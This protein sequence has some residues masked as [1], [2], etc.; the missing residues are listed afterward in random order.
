MYMYNVLNKNII[1]KI[2]TILTTYHQLVKE[3]L[4]NLYYEI[5]N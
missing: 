1:N 5:T 4:V 2:K 3:L